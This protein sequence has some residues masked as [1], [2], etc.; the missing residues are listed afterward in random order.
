MRIR[1]VVNPAASRTTPQRRSAVRDALA[2]D[3]D[4]SVV[5]TERRDHAT[6]LAREALADGVDSVAVLGGDGTLNEVA[7]ALVGSR[8]AVMALPGGGTNVFCRTLGLPDDPAT[9]AQ[10]MSTALTAGASHRI[11][12][13]AIEG[14]GPTGRDLRHFCFHTGVGWDAEV[15]A[16]VEQH[17]SLK[18]RLGHALFV[19]AGVR[20]FFG[21]YDRRRPHFRVDV[22]GGPT[23]HDAFFSIV[24]NSDPYTYVGHRPFVVDPD[25]DAT[26]PFTVVVLRSMR[27]RHFLLVMADALRGRG[28]SARPWLV[29]RDDVTGV[30]IRRT[31]SLP[32]QVDGDHLGD[33]GELRM[34]YRPDALTIVVPEPGAQ[35]ARH[36]GQRR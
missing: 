31:T 36:R 10:M 19:Y 17:A 14:T 35:P 5:M 7:H 11:G 20:T 16:V 18:R 22:D 21:S 33:A 8:C 30:T 25:N 26:A 29:L 3:H 2:A 24:M 32:Y 12:V 23:V 28:L 4:V 15:V 9:A 13:G 27:V 34:T 1:L 6:E